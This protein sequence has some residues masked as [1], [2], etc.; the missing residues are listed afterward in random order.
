[1]GSVLLLFV[2]AFGD[3]K[4]LLQSYTFFANYNPFARIIDFFC[5][6]SSFRHTRISACDVLVQPV[7]QASSRVRANMRTRV[8]DFLVAPRL[9]IRQLRAFC[10]GCT[11]GQFGCTG[12]QFGCTGGGGRSAEFAIRPHR[13]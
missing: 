2:F 3:S 7:P 1:M 13:V 6:I 10:F 8:S 12:E 9:C 11:G 5:D 4:S